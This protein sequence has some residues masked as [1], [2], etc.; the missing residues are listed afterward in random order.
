[1]T[2]HDKLIHELT[3]LDQRE[4][5][6]SGHNPYAIA[7]YFR[8]AE[9]VVDAQ[10]FADAFIPTK[11]MHRVARNLRLPLDVQAGRWVFLS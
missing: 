2:F 4:A 7:H 5:K 10:S 6:R 8:A 1:M 9:G 3:A 11:G